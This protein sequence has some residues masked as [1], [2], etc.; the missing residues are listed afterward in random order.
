[1]WLCGIIDS[2]VLSVAG[3]RRMS[4]GLARKY[5]TPNAL[6]DVCVGLLPSGA[7]GSWSWYP[8]WLASVR[9]LAQA[10][11]EEW[12]ESW[13]LGIPSR[14]TLVEIRPMAA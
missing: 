4:F 7:V 5:Y 14:R 10:R 2:V 9:P 1:M 6:L 13:C 12:L 3:D 11:L 8:S